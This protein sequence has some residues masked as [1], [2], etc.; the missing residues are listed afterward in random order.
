MLPGYLAL[1]Y[2]PARIEV[3]H[4]LRTLRTFCFKGSN[5]RALIRHCFRLVTFEDYGAKAQ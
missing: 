4:Q 2:Y 1:R 5:I 3:L